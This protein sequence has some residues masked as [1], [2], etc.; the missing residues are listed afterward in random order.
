MIFKNIANFA[1]SGSIA[2]KLARLEIDLKTLEITE[3]RI[4]SSVS[5]GG[6]PGAESSI[7]KI[8]YT[9]LE[10]HINE[11]AV[12]V[13]GYRGFALDVPEDLSGIHGDYVSSIVPRYL[14]NR[15]ASIFGGSEE[16]QRNI[17]AKFVLGL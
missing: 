3:L 17:I 1:S 2:R 9:E 15:A 6:N 14:N 8:L 12:E 4:L 11:L 10:Q 5:S 7:T 13:I 16:V